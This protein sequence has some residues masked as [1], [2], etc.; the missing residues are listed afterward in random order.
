[1]IM[2]HCGS[3]HWLMNDLPSKNWINNPDQFIPTSHRRTTLRDPYTSEYDRKLFS[4][5]WFAKT[6]PDLNQRN[7]E[8]STYLIQ[9]T[10]W[11]IEYLGLSD[12]RM[13]PYPYSD[14]NFMRDWTCAVMN[15][16]PY[17]NICGE[18]WTLNPAIL[19][20]LI[21]DMALY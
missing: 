6:I 9:N 15:E 8:M 7:P 11:W 21:S 20:Y 3:G 2:N 13:S 12:I 5:G 4:D 17:F 10:I 19:A 1:M 16:Y 18:E 14:K